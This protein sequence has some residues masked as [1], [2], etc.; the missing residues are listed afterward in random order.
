MFS[1]IRFLISYL[2]TNEYFSL[3]M[4]YIVLIWFFWGSVFS[5]GQH[6]QV[7]GEFGIAEGMPQVTVFALTQDQFGRIWAGTSQ[8]LVYYNGYDILPTELTK[9]KIYKLHRKG[10]YLFAVSPESLIKIH[11]R[12]FKM[13]TYRFHKVSYRP[14]MFFEKYIKLSYE[15]SP[16]YL[17]YEL[18]E[19]RNVEHKETPNPAVKALSTSWYKQHK[20]NTNG[21][22][23]V[24]QNHY[25][26]ATYD[27][28]YQARLRG[29]TWNFEKKL[30]GAFETVLVD[31]EKNI[32]L[33]TSSKGM[34]FVHRNNLVFHFNPVFHDKEIVENCWSLFEWKNQT[35]VCTSNGVKRVDGKPSKLGELTKGLNTVS[36]F[37]KGDFVI[38]GTS[39]AGVFKI[40]KDELTKIVDH[41][42]SDKPGVFVQI[43]QNDKGIVLVEQFKIIQLD[44]LGNKILRIVE[45]DKKDASTIFYVHQTST[46][47]LIANQKGITV[48]DENFE[49][50]QLIQTNMSACFTMILPYKKG[51]ACT[52]LE[53]YV[54]YLKDQKLEKLSSAPN[55][56][57]TLSMPHDE[58][59]WMTTLSSLDFFSKGKILKLFPEN[60]VPIKEF[61]QAG[62]FYSPRNQMY[63]C[64]GL[65]GV[66]WFK[67]DEVAKKFDFPVVLISNEEKPLKTNNTYR[68]DFDMGVISLNL[69]KI[70]VT[71]RNLFLTEYFDGEK[72]TELTKNKTVNLRL[73]YG[74]NDFKVRSKN[75]FT[76]ET[77]TNTI[78]LFRDF[79]I[80]QRW[81]FIAFLCVLVGLV[82]GG[83][84][85]LWKH[86]K[87]RKE[88]K[89]QLQERKM[90]DER[91]RISRELHDN[92]GARITHIIS[93]LDI[94]AYKNSEAK[95]IDKI[96]NFARETMT[97][98][99]ETI[100]AVSAKEI[101]FS[102]FVH[103]IEQYVRQ[104]DQL[105]TS[106]I[107]CEKSENL[108]DFLLTPTQLINYYRTIQEA[109]NNAV[110]YAEPTTICVEF[111]E[112]SNS[113]TILVQITDDGIGFDLTKEK[114]GTGIKSMRER[115]EEV[116]GKME[117]KS[118]LG[119][120]TRII[121]Y[122]PVNR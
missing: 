122:L 107:R 70:K 11:T 3:E 81:W 2:N 58:S 15:N 76:E 7:N 34:Q 62:M 48:C 86:T 82:F 118:E 53:G 26:I 96:S 69:E 120:G 63:Y 49:N 121:L 117:V 19:V 1:I 91:M 32:W 40:Y 22:Q 31:D 54:Y 52:S 119:K 93:S 23:K 45:L 84:Y 102:Q 105:S 68:F 88:L 87:T 12:T 71:D 75:V 89:I 18:K 83:I 30:E 85:L 16:L 20:L 35:Y 110:K 37:A 50:M 103:R 43:F 79:P 25:L 106:Q 6:W 90:S 98:L 66:M 74:E 8:G 114:L 41:K 36:A 104:I 67:S 59:F 47:Y 64:S 14:C 24:N 92:I 78:S 9:E 80:W 73:K 13:T 27:G 94:E 5:Y 39:R 33:G 56:A 38:V 17:D 51:Y 4:R 10:D 99:R 97:Q 116:G 21:I 42:A 109:I 108:P 115:M 101:A 77:Q 65:G 61:N 111:R 28:L 46:G 72:W 112:E 100:W 57:L 44:T 55:P 29:K 113:D 60:G 95:S